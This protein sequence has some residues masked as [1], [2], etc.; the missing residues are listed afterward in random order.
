MENSVF[1]GIDWANDNH[2]V[3][4]VDA[5]GNKMA[6]FSV[7]HSASGMEQL[8]VRLLELAHEPQ[9]CS[10]AIELNRGAIVEGLLERGFKVFGIN[11]KQTDRFRDRH[12]PAGAKDDRRDAYVLGDA[13]RTDRHRFRQL[14][15]GEPLIIQLREAS[16]THDELRDDLAALANRLREQLH[17]YFPQLLKLSPAANEPWLW[18]LLLKAPTPHK[19][20]RLRKGQLAKILKVHRIRRFSAAE[21]HQA[22]ALPAL[23][24]AAGS[25][26]AAS[27]HVLSLIPRLRTNH[28]QLRLCDRR[29]EEILNQLTQNEPSSD[30]EPIEHRD[31][32]ILLSLPGVGKLNGAAMLAEAFQPLRDRDYYTLR[33]LSGVAPVTRQ[34][35]KRRV[36]LMRRA[37]NP[38]LR[39]AIHTWA[40]CSIQNDESSKLFYRACRARGL[41]HAHALRSLGDHLLRTLFAM[42]RDRTLYDA[43]RSHASNA[44]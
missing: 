33:N 42:L 7:E 1:V 13:L 17:R 27:E 39:D 38:R 8:A 24:L 29:L 43:S 35:G 30:S 3:C 32:A 37:C 28:E 15:L 21:L 36:V 44:A 10:V 23:K 34:T 26:E 20:R 19:A 11:P 6:E 5:V 14:E 2:Q 40:A 41:K 4:V 25:V 18:A 31:A 22:L 12:G 16:R 9:R